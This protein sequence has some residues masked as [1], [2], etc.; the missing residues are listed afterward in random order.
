M[1]LVTECCPDHASEWYAMR[2][3]AQKLGIGT[4]ETVRKWVRGAHADAGVRP[5]VSSE[6]SAERCSLKA[7]AKSCGGR[8]RF[9]RPRRVSRGPA[10]PAT[11]DLV[12]FVAE[13]A[14]RR[15]VERAAL[16]GRADLP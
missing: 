5:G 4:T 6:E 3:V 12:R 1:R 16:G 15:T 9:S 2:S 10:R 11:P 14:D 7:E 13:H 8:M